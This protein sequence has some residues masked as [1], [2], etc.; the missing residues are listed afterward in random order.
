MIMKNYGFIEN[1]EQ[2]LDAL[3][4]FENKNADTIKYVFISTNKYFAKWR[5]NELRR[6]RN[7]LSSTFFDLLTLS[8]LK[9]E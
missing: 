5:W 1:T 9:I 3:H 8:L 6:P 2:Q 4:I 7:A